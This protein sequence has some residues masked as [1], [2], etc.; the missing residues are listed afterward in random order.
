MCNIMDSQ[1]I[2]EFVIRSDDMQCCLSKLEYVGG[3]VAQ[4]VARCQLTTLITNQS[5]KTQGVPI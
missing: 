5:N 4:N 1:Q 2:W 3:D